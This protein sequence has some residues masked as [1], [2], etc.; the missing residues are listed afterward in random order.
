LPLVRSRSAGPGPEKPSPPSRGRGG[1]RF[2]RMS[3]RTHHTYPSFPPPRP[4]PAQSYA[5]KLGREQNAA[6]DG[7]A[8]LQLRSPLKFGFA[9]GLSRPARREPDRLTPARVH[10]GPPKG[11]ATSS[12][13]RFSITT[14]ARVARRAV[15]GR[16]SPESCSLVRAPQ[17]FSIT[18]TRPPT[19]FDHDLRSPPRP[20]DP[21]PPR[22][23]PPPPT[24]PPPPARPPPRT[25]ARPE[26]ALTPPSS[27][28][29]RPARRS[30]APPAPLS[31][32]HGG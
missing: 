10:F 25:R 29:A 22:T 12:P 6:F 23:R 8:Q 27:P 1:L 32:A 31:P 21:A 7:P 4:G 30:R 2:H 24:P 14:P 5:R 17:R 11:L 15:Q 3:M 26:P 20:R 13:Q 16:H 19:V 18:S 9:R 28:R